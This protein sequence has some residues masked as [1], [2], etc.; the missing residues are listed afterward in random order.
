VYIRGNNWKGD[1]D[2]AEIE[3][4]LKNY[5][6][7]ITK[8]GS[9]LVARA[10]RK[11]RNWND[12]KN[13][14]S[15]SF[16]ISCPEK[17]S[18]D[19]ETSGGS[20][21]MKKLNGS[22]KI[23]TSGGS[24]TL[25]SISGKLKGGTSGGSISLDDCHNSIDLSTSGG[26][27]TADDSDGDIKLE[28]SG[29]S[30]N[31]RNLQGTIHGSTSGGS[32]RADNIKGEFIT[33]T[34]GGGIH[35]KNISASLDASTSG[36]GIEAEITSLGK[37][38]KLETSAGG[39]NVTMPMNKGMDL[40]LDANKVNISTLNNFSGTKEKDRVK[41]KVNGGGVLVKM[42]ASSGNITIN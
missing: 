27:I 36:G 4:R 9:Q 40:D 35:L 33:S 29:G 16:K 37:Y 15:I 23:N 10:E 7:N 21:T 8:E 11:N 17:V 13:G 41:G 26:S 34:S 28:T 38:L 14:L 1:L 42:E 3:E 18:T 32:I 30:L 25:R 2:K 6:I 12:W 31:F 22:Q 5:T 20:I 19:V 39:I 24:I